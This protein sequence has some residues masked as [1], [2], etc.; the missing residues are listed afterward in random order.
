MK[1]ETIVAGAVAGLAGGV[2]YLVAMEADLAV[3]GNDAD[4][5]QLLGGLVVKD[6]AGARRLGL[7]VHLGNSALL[8]IV[9]AAVGRK[10]L[11][12]PGWARG[13]TFASIENAALYPL[14]LL[15]DLHPAIR[16]GRIARY[17]TSTSFA[18]GVV[19]HVAYGAVMGGVLD[20]LPVGKP[21]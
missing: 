11:P 15:E 19:R 17:W 14:T 6:R 16:D 2:A 9:Y 8:G 5:L 4:D 10:L 20:R 7:A 12:G 1:T 3:T 13:V 21:A 18:Q